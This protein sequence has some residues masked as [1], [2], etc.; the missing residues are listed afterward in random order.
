M[1][2]EEMKSKLM[3]ALE[4]AVDECL[5]ADDEEYDMEDEEDEYSEDGD[6]DKR[7]AAV[8]IGFKK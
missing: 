8:I 5:E 1:K 7:K 2:K 6:K 4:S 3:A